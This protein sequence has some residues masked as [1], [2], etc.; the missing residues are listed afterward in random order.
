MDIIKLEK[1]TRGKHQL[2]ITYSFNDYRFE[3]ALWY[4]NVNLLELEE[5]H[6][7]A[8][9]DVIYFHIAAFE[10]NKLTSLRPQQVDFGSYK[11]FCTNH[12]FKLWTIVQ[13]K[14]WAQWRYE[15]DAP[16]YQ[17]T[18]AHECAPSMLIKISNEIGATK[19][20]SFCGGGKDSLV[21][22]R[23]FETLGIPYASFAYS[24]SIYGTAQKQHRIINRLLEGLKPKKIHRQYVYDSFVDCPI[25]EIDKKIASK[26]ITAAET[27]SSI[28]ASLP[29][30]LSEGYRY[31]ALGHE[32]SANVGNLIWDKTG[33]DVNHQWGKSYA[34]EM[35]INNYIQ[36]NLIDN[37]S[38][39]SILQPIYD[40][41]I[42]NL[43]RENIDLVPQT[44]SCNI[45]KPWCKKCAK[46]AYV[47]LN[48]MAYLPTK[49]VNDMFDN[50]NLFDLEENQL[51]F[52]QMVGLGEHTPFECI[53]RIEESRL[54]FHLC[55]QK[56]LTG[57]ALFLYE[58][59]KN[60]DFHAIAINFTKVDAEQTGYPP[61]IKTEILEHLQNI[62]KKSMAYIQ[63]FG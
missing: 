45:E 51:S 54:A 1:I 8:Y 61:T 26:A 5:Q 21:S 59:F 20:L 12:F 30:V 53:G 57:K 22:A 15:N 36:E 55:R 29:I 35:L 9:L 47:W 62:S 19:I 27:P 23:I 16:D 24:N 46:C 18:L 25:L 34:A 39:F 3:V 40:V 48:Y 56:G 60:D 38:Y 11:Q 28:F 4:D 37:F 14:V 49:L 50:V 31:I 32:K 44:H 33:E 7:A 10:L 13:Q 63:S 17:V 41:V 6:G 52:K 58:A 43:L 42:F 2:S